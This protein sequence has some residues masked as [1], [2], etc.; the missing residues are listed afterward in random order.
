MPVTIRRAVPEDAEML[1]RL[2][3]TLFEQTYSGS[4]PP[5]DMAPY[6]DEAY[7]TAQQ[8]SELTD[9]DVVCLL[10]E[11]KDTA[12]GFAQVRKRALPAT[13][14]ASANVELWRIY[15]DRRCHGLGIARR[16]LQHIGHA[17]RGMGASG[18]WLSVW[19][20]N[21]RAISFYTKHG[22]VAVGQADFRLGDTVQSDI[23]LRADADSF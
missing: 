1:A 13:V 12:V 8:L 4:I 11:D 21:P 5:G 20:E 16:L 23:I 19:N 7:G 3:A 14:T 22:F 6:L 10:V 15:L 2:G 9:P 18:I 17:A